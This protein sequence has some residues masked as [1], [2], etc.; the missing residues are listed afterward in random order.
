MV[1]PGT[2]PRSVKNYMRKFAEFQK[3]NFTFLPVNRFMTEIFSSPVN[4]LQSNDVG[5]NL[6]L[7]RFLSKSSGVRGRSPRLDNGFILEARWNC[8]DSHAFT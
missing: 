2:E 3:L 6:F 5:S 1:V 7:L 4:L 8:S